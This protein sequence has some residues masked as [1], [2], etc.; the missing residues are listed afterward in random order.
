MRVSVP[1]DG[2]A[3]LAAHIDLYPHPQVC[4][5]LDTSIG[6]G[7]TDDAGRIVRP[8]RV[9][10]F[11]VG[12]LALVSRASDNKAW[13]AV[14]S[15]GLRELQDQQGR[16]AGTAHYGYRLGAFLCNLCS[17]F[18]PRTI[19]LSG[20]IPESHWDTFSGPL[21]EEFAAAGP[22]WL[23]WPRIERSPYG[24]HAALWGMAKYVSSRH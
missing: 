10:N 16:D 5:F 22:R 7:L 13:W 4:L 18:Q 23:E 9:S 20:G 24:R 2:E 15:G 3:H 12:E 11:D 14:G 6:F 19:V 17:L 1:N 8:R 21:L